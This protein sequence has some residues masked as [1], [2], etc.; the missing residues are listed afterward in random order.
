MLGIWLGLLM[1]VLLFAGYGAFS[2]EYSM[3]TQV[4][5]GLTPVQ[6]GL[7]LT[8]F[9]GAFV[10]AGL[11]MPHIVARF[12]DRTME[13]AAG[14]DRLLRSARRV[15]RRGAGEPIRPTRRDGDGSGAP[16]VTGLAGGLFTTAQQASLGLGIATIGGLFG[17]LALARL[18]ARLRGRTRPASG[19]DRGVLGPRAAAPHAFAPPTGAGPH[20]RFPLNQEKEGSR[21]DQDGHY[22][23]AS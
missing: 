1:T 8:A 19:H 18:A 4:G 13:L 23:Q 7:A 2:Y 10:L 14:L 21:H 20:H 6:S 11:R 5:L 12:G 15:P 3:L 16:R 22:P 9:A 17:A